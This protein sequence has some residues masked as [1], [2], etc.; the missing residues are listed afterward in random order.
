M[1]VLRGVLHVEYTSGGR[2][3]P[4]YQDKTSALAH[5]Q[6]AM[7]ADD[8]DL[9]AETRSEMQHMVKVLD[10]ACEWWGMCISVEKTTVRSWQWENKKKPS[11]HPWYCKIMH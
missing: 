5:I 4:V 9:V 7:Y 3:V 6:D 8:M 2:A 1:S 11:I 10:K